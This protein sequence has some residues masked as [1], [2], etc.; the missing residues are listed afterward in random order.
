MYLLKL[1]IPVISTSTAEV[2]EM[3]VRTT[4]ASVVRRFAFSV[5]AVVGFQFFFC[6]A[7]TLTSTIFLGN[8]LFHFAKL[9]RASCSRGSSL[10]PWTSAPSSPFAR[11]K[12]AFAGVLK[13]VFILEQS[14]SIP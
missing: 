14:V 11:G 8:L 3:T 5:K 6:F 7:T 9:L 2:P 13:V 12:A 4:F 1:D 10:G